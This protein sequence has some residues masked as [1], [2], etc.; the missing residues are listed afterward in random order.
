MRLLFV[1]QRYGPEIAGGAEQHCRAIAE[2]M[3]ARGHHVEVATTCA[4]SYLDWVDV[5]E[6]G[7]SVVNGVRVQ[8]FPVAFARSQFFDRLNDRA[9]TGRG[10]RT[11]LL[12]REWMRSQ[13]PYAPDLPRWLLRNANRFDCVVCFT[14][15]YWTTWAALDALTGTVPL[16]LHPTVHDEPPLRLSLFDSVFHAPDA[17]AFSTPEEIDLIRT[18]FHVDPPGAVIG[19]GVETKPTDAA[20]FR[21][22]YVPGG[23]P[24]LLYAGRL[25]E[26]KGAGELIEFFRAYKQRHRAPLK[27]VMVGDGPMHISATDDVVVTGFV[28][29]ASRDAALA[30]ALALAQPS[31][32]ESFS[33]VLTEAFAH[34]RPALVQGRCDVL[35]GHARRSGA[36]FP[37]EGFAEFECGLEMLADQP[38]LADAMGAAGRAY[39]ER[40]YSWP[41]VLDRYEALLDRVISGAAVRGTS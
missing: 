29:D 19:V 4:Q 39:V 3:A 31:Y 35:R 37:Y 14:Y 16:V 20:R 2:R 36:A 34:G 22:A 13:G 30:G 33:M 15:L 26:G 17:F 7:S 21:A 38:G 27:L 32:L 23:E 24:F 6:P 10:V 18:R 8:R 28:D 41:V 25:D 12:Q 1:V 5:F 40:E 11:M 9:T